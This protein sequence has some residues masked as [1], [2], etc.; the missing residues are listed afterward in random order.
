MLA[1][2][3]SEDGIDEKDVCL[4]GLSKI[5]DDVTV[6]NDSLVQRLRAATYRDSA[7]NALVHLDVF[8]KFL[9]PPL[10]DSLVH[11]KPIFDP[12]INSLEG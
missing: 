3:F 9:M 1:R 10:D 8:A 11:I 5:Y 2:Y 4:V 7:V 6:L 12:F